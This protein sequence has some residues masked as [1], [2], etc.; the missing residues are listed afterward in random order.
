M[1]LQI[2]YL[3]SE[4]NSTLA[5]AAQGCS[6]SA[7]AQGFAL[8]F[9]NNVGGFTANMPTATNTRHGVMTPAHVVSLESLKTKIPAIETKLNDMPPVVGSALFVYENAEGAINFYSGANL[10]F[11]VTIHDA[12]DTESGLMSAQEHRKL[13]RAAVVYY[14]KALY[15]DVI[16]EPQGAPV[17]VMNPELVFDTLNNVLLLKTGNA[18]NTRYYRA[19]V[20]DS[21]GNGNGDYTQE[22]VTINAEGKE[23]YYHDGGW[24]SSQGTNGGVTTYPFYKW[25]TKTNTDEI[26]ITS[27]D[28]LPT[29]TAV[30][31][32][33]KRGTYGKAQSQAMG[34]TEGRAHY[35]G[36]A[37]IEMKCTLTRIGNGRYSVK[38]QGYESFADFMRKTPRTPKGKQNGYNLT[39]KCAVVIERNGQ[40]I[41]A[42]V[43]FRVVKSA[44]DSP[45][46]MARW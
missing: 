29:D 2:N 42:P 12:T 40:P 33:Y 20:K 34:Y 9:T 44:D 41:T 31:Y 35:N 17:I 15:T 24:V 18:A 4:I 21:N 46:T 26:V 38:P 3:A 11:S 5:N 37:K 27:K 30:V 36:W 28:I 1:S 23:Y 32:R 39:Y 6:A 14:A 16:V 25:T 45:Y 10:A 7:T 22:G 19:W 8:N 13:E 43:R